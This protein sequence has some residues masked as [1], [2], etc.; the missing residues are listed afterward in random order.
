MLQTFNCEPNDTNL[1]S[2]NFVYPEFKPDEFNIYE[3]HTI[4][5][6]QC[7]FFS[8]EDA[9]KADKLPLN[10]IIRVN[11]HANAF[12]EYLKKKIDKNLVVF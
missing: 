1:Y 5:D 11:L 9:K 3:P 2:H 12:A 8:S 6:W 4:L 7:F 10:E